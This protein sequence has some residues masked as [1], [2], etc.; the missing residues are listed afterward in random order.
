VDP[1]AIAVGAMLLPVPNPADTLSSY[2]PERFAVS[3]N[4]CRV[5]PATREERFSSNVPFT[6]VDG[7]RLDVRGDRFDR[8]WRFVDGS[9]GWSG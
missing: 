8:R 6:L 2:P 3:V 9:A 5:G 1:L 7:W 4:S